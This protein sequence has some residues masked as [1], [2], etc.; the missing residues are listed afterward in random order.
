MTKNLKKAMSQAEK[1]EALVGC[2]AVSTALLFIM[3]G[4]M[5]RAVI[6][7]FIYTHILLALFPTLPVLGFLVILGLT[8]LIRL[9]F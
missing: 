6:F 5:L 7:Y 9:V 3:L 4:T 2:V 1:E 8:V